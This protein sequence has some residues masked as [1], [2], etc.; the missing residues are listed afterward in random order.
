MMSRHTDAIA[1]AAHIAARNP[2]RRPAELA[3]SAASLWSPSMWRAVANEAGLGDSGAWVDT[4]TQALTVSILAHADD[5]ATVTLTNRAASI[6]E[7]ALTRF[8][9]SLVDDITADGRTENLGSL[10]ADTDLALAELG[11]EVAAPT[12][13][14]A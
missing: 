13:E 4:A 10:L 14:A 3:R 11:H 8:R 12:P 6:A 7:V 5:T 1:L 9:R 2:D